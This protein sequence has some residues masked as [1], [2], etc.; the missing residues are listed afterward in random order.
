MYCGTFTAGGLKV[1]VADG[2]LSIAHEGKAKKYVNKVEQVTF[3]GRYATKVRQPVMFI[4][5]RAVFELRDGHL[6]LT[7]VAPGIDIEKDILAHMEFKPLMTEPP[8]AMLAGIFRPKW[9]GL[10][11]SLT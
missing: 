1:A 5:E 6:A 3:S 10:K 11:G 4:T 9:G 8:K 2:K 7:E